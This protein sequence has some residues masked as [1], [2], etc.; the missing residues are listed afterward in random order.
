MRIEAA[1]RLHPAWLFATLVFIIYGSLV[2]LDFHPHSLAWAWDQFQRTPML[3]L[4]IES[5]AD[6]IANGVLYLPAG[7]LLAERFVGRLRGL[8]LGSTLL[9]SIAALA[10]IAFGVEFTQLFFPP[11]T[12]SQNDLLA[13]TI[14]GALGVLLALP[15][16]NSIRRI[17]AFKP[18]HGT[19]GVTLL[20]GVYMAAYLAF[21]F[22]PFDFLLS[23]KEISAKLASDRWGLL[24]AASQ[25][26]Y[27]LRTLITL[28]IEVAAVLPFG[29]F[30][31]RNAR[32]RSHPE[33][34][35]GRMTQLT[36]QLII[37]G[38]LLGIS[39]ETLQL[40]TYS[41]S[42]QG[43]SVIT[44]TLGVYIGG[45]LWVTMGVK[46]RSPWHESWQS[47]LQRHCVLLTLLY[48]LGL[49]LFTSWFYR[50]WGSV[51]SAQDALG[52]L[53]FLPFYYHYY[54]SEANALTSLISVALLFAPLGILAQ[55][56]QR[57]LLLSTYAPAVLAALIETAK[58]FSTSTHADPTNILIAVVMARFTF[59][60]VSRMIPDSPTPP[61]AHD[62]PR[63]TDDADRA[64]A[65][66]ATP[67]P[68]APPAPNTATAP[69]RPT[70][71][72]LTLLMLAAAGVTY[73]L[74]HFPVQP[75][76]LAA[77]LAASTLAVW[78]KP[79]AILLIIP[80]A[81]PILDLAPWSGRFYLD[82]LDALLAIT[83]ATGYARTA[84]SS[85]PWHPA[86]KWALIFLA[87]SFFF[88]TLQALL[89]WSMPDISSFVNYFS[90][91]NALRISK[92]FVWTLL[93]IGLTRRIDNAPNQR[94]QW[95]AWGMALGL[96]AVV[97]TMMR[98]KIMFGG[99]LNFSSDYR[100]TG[101]FSA[102]H[103]GGAYVECY[104]AV[105]TPFLLYLTITTRRWLL[106]IAGTALLLASTYALMAT[107][108]RNGF[109]GYAVA[110]GLAL[111]A[112]MAGQDK[113]LKRFVQITLLAGAALAVAVPLFEGSFVQK[114]MSEIG[115][116]L[117]VRTAHWHDGLSIR[118]SGWL[119][120]IFGM[121]IGRFPD[122]HFWRSREPFHPS[123]HAV[124]SEADNTFL[125]IAPGSTL[126]VEQIVAI[127]PHQR[128]RLRFD[129][130]S[131]TSG[132]TV[133]IALCEK[134]MLASSRCAAWNKSQVTTQAGVW[135]PVEQLIDSGELGSG[136]WFSQRPV[137][138]SFF[139]NGSTVVDIDNIHFIP[140][141]GTDRITNA[142]FSHGMDHWYFATDEHLAWHIKSMPL[143]ILF[144]QGWFG[145][146]GFGLFF[147]VVFGLAGRAA[148]RGNPAAGVS[149]AATAGFLVVGLFDTLIDTPRFLF[150]L[151]VL[152]LFAAQITQSPS[153]GASD[154]LRADHGP[155]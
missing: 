79:V 140:E 63:K 90:P 104:L 31:A 121:G 27:G 118:D 20:L 110:C 148:W 151:L 16:S 25:P 11:R 128:Y 119:T 50:P 19:Q 129:L 123:V 81:L 44:R 34:N 59:L 101:P 95:F 75:L 52:K 49:A 13:E 131:A 115:N 107:V 17:A 102:I 82:E 40:F 137:K 14:G 28:A 92:G 21:C 74:V 12:V 37:S 89:P 30:I 1:P 136:Q 10:L 112:L 53:H 80:A 55:L 84:A 139:T 67:T 76:L 91:F 106:R 114:R 116:D 38:L 15:L 153:P 85:N 64:L 42:S 134:W 71:Q 83:L 78:H 97:A 46:M 39:I 24:F 77:L 29:I 149:L 105:A 152:A 141:H 109:A 125:R 130:R 61:A 87:L 146:L 6:W 4:G 124:G 54:V 32:R 88:S 66:I 100:A 138:L 62:I 93:F 51:D 86:L 60:I 68:P 135:Q 58:L 23:A 145:V 69:K 26:G 143:A 126:Y 103:T 127:E 122:A 7:F 99:L 154:K 150:L 155:D 142:D 8:A 72:H 96:A 35:D 43:V 9:L 56:S 132:N 113:K 18:A 57:R 48:M 98:E 144:D 3:S 70:A 36:L 47:I 133:G 73:W 111:L 120:E 41:G 5:R 147:I 2:P 108:S 117:G 45:M 65:P 94:F 22:F 33:T